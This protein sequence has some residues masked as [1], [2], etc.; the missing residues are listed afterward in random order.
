M[1]RFGNFLYSYFIFRCYTY[2]ISMFNLYHFSTSLFDVAYC[3]R[4]WHVLVPRDYYYLSYY[5]K[6]ILWIFV[7][8]NQSRI[9]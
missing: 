5:K 4:K 6:K 1:N 7:F 2:I 8:I 3:R 9:V